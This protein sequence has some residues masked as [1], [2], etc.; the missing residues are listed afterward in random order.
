MANRN[1]E[2]QNAMERSGILKD[3]NAHCLSSYA[4]KLLANITI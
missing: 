3:I 1:G 2:D 4:S